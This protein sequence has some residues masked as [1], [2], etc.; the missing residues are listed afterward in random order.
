MTFSH[1]I[2]TNRDGAA[3]RRTRVGVDPHV[4]AVLSVVVRGPDPNRVP[5][6]VPIGKRDARFATFVHWIE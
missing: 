4:P 5:L 2:L 1:Q 3:A 6:G